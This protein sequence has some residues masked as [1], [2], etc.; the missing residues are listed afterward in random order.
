MDT[1]ARLHATTHRY[2][3][4][5]NWFLFNV[6]ARGQRLVEPLCATNQRRANVADLFLLNALASGQWLF[7][8]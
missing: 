4:A 8:L 5:A 1:N 7:V 2:A 6:H 3:N